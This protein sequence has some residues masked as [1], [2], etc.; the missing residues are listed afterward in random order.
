MDTDKDG[1]L[2]REEVIQGAEQH[3][4]GKNFDTAPG[5]SSFFKLFFI[6]CCAIPFY[7]FIIPHPRLVGIIRLLNST[8]R[9]RFTTPNSKMK[10]VFRANSTPHSNS[11][12]ESKGQKFPPK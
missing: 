8:F 5:M 6:C 4:L 10:S 12:F 7:F 11:N 9:E 1:K 2:T 3:F